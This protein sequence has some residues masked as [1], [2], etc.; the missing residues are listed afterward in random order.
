MVKEFFIFEDEVRPI[1][2]NNFSVIN[3]QNINFVGSTANPLSGTKQALMELDTTELFNS[4]FK[5][6]LNTTA[7]GGIIQFKPSVAFTDSTVY[8][9][10]LGVT[11]ASGLVVWNSASFIYLANS[12][13]G[14]NQSHLYQHF[15]STFSH[16]SLDSLS[17]QLFFP[18]RTI[19]FSIEQW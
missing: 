10:R 17:R 3:K 6:S 4:P 16:I 11:P 9:W 5:I 15:K 2:P 18:A 12:S 13:S 1:Y 7:V 8:Y 14:W 19:E